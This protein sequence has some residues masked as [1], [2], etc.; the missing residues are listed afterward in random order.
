MDLGRLLGTMLSQAERRG[1]EVLELRPGQVVRGVLL[2][3]LSEQEAL[4]A[5]YGKMVKAELEVPIPIGQATWFQVQP[6]AGKGPM[7]L[8]PL[9]S[10]PK[11]LSEE[12]AAAMLKQIGLKDA[13]L[14]RW[15][16]RLLQQE[17]VPLKK[18]TVLSVLA[19]L[20]EG[21][22][23]K[24]AEPWIRAAAIAAKR[25]LP[26]TA[27]TVR[28]IHTAMHGPTPAELGR[29][30]A[31]GARELL[32]A[33][34]A[35]AA[36]QQ[37]AARLLGALQRADALLHGALQPQAAASITRGARPEGPAPAPPPPSSSGGTVSAPA[38]AQA[39][40]PSAAAS[41]PPAP[42]APAPLRAFFQA[43][44]LDAERQWLRLSDSQ[45]PA[46]MPPQPPAPPQPAPAAQP[47]EPTAPAIS[48]AGPSAA[49]FGAERAEAHHP[50][51]LN[52]RPAAEQRLNPLLPL[53]SP[54]E[55]A[56]AA[57]PGRL[58]APQ[59]TLKSALAQLAA[60]EDAP[61][62]LKE[63]AQT[64][65]QSL[66]GQQ[67]LLAAADRSSPFV[68]VM[69]WIPLPGRN[70]SEDGSAAVQLH[71]RRGKTGELD[72]NNCRLWFQLSLAALGETWID[73]QVVDR[74]VSLHVWND[75]PA[76]E[77]LFAQSKGTVEE[78]LAGIGYHLSS[79]RHSPKP[80]QAADPAAAPAAERSIGP[81][82]YKGVDLR[83]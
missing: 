48:A 6:D 33:P 60:V 37:A 54:A 51:P 67:L 11:G 78:A 83:V 58:S 17:D 71:T 18:P 24:A 79:F 12:A 22:S 30:L 2:Q 4:L 15:V 10:S 66:Q 32:A 64:A 61:P 23:A 28:A 52:S 53:R 80:K 77:S 46:K 69:M 31:Q 75:H 62:A 74:I 34:Q 57:E 45:P 29:A 70:G 26:V 13:P 39:P 9:V 49:D 50:A 27:E 59:E 36:A 1:G 14:H 20:P 7:R 68:H 21:L 8:K 40:Q 19:A 43:L 82:A 44:G 73:V 55:A 3:L 63:A 81:S 42:A 16:L 35:S 47:Q 25:Q 76:A 65:L 56:P 72:A 5:M 41:P 38:A